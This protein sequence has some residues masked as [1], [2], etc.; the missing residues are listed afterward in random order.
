MAKRKKRFKLPQEKDRLVKSVWKKSPKT[1]KEIK[2]L[3]RKAKRIVKKQYTDI[4]PESKNF[5]KLTVGIL[6]RMAKVDESTSLFNVLYESYVKG[7][8]DNE[9]QT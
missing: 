5:Y 3:Y 4:E 1:R 8:N 9:N 6:K 7:N 2:R